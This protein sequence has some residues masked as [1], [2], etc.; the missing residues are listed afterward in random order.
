MKLEPEL[1]LGSSIYFRMC[2]VKTVKLVTILHL[3]P[4]ALEYIFES[5]C[6]MCDV[7]C[8]R[9]HIFHLA[10]AALCI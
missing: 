9:T 1:E 6:K 5:R 10:L 4:A 7:M 8:E 2:D 3:A